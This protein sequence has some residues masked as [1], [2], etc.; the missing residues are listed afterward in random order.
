[1][2]NGDRS[3]ARRATNKAGLIV[4]EGKELPC[5]FRDVSAT[6]ARVRVLNSNAPERFRLISSM[7]KLDRLCTVVWR[8]GADAG[9]RFE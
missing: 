4:A 8:R 2:T 9:V 7:E 1:M 3:A 6:G 5:L